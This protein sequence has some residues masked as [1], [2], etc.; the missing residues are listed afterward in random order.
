MGA[1]FLILAGVLLTGA[2]GFFVDPEAPYGERCDQVLVRNLN[3]LG[4]LLGRIGIVFL[5]SG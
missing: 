3:T 5:A 2:V 4:V 1:L